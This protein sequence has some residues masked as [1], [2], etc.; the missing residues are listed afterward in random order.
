MNQEHQQA[1][2]LDAFLDA[3]RAGEPVTP[4]TVEAQL[5]ADLV[6]LASSLQLAEPKPQPRPPTPPPF[7]RLGEKEAFMIAKRHPQAVSS[8]ALPLIAVVLLI[9]FLGALLPLVNQPTSAPP[10]QDQTRLPIPVGGRLSS[11]DPTALNLMRDAGMEWAVFQVEYAQTDS[12]ALIESTR[13][14]I[15]S[16]HQQGFRVW[17]TLSQGRSTAATGELF[18]PEE[19]FD[20]YAE[21]A[22][23]IAALGADALQVWSEPNLSVS[24][25]NQHPDPANYV[26]LLRVSYEAIKTANPATLVISAAPAPTSAQAAFGSD[27]IW[28]DDLFYQAM[29]SFGADYA[30]CIGV[31][32]LEGV[33]D[34]QQTEGDPRDNYPTRYFVPMIQRAATPFRESGLPVCLSEY[35]YLA[36]E[37]ET[38]PQLFEWANDT[39]VAQQAEWL[40]QG[41][42]TAAELSSVRVQMV[43]LYRVDPTGDIV[44]DG[45]AIIREDGSCPACDAIAALKQ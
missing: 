16:V 8:P 13:A 17:I 24:W 3:Y 29:A 44:E 20:H 9:L 39:T 1:D 35:G 4:P 43:M 37:G 2:A 23:Q 12:E 26:E 32:Y 42:Q 38:L 5:A 34:P 19:G 31:N 10:V 25:L 14:L 36:G 33:L 11:V 40:A 22:G 41:I 7:T 45:Y 15:N 21:M 28:N 18:T 27:Q 30:D 6:D